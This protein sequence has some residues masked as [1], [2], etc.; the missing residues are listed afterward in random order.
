MRVKLGTCKIDYGTNL[1]EA[2]FVYILKPEIGY[3]S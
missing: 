3:D 2:I 1:E